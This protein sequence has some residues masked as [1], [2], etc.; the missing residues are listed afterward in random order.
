HKGSN[1]ANDFTRWLARKVI[2]L[3]TLN[4]ETG[5]ELVKANPGLFRDTDLL[6]MANA[7][8]SLAP[9]SPIFPVIAEA[10]YSPDVKYHNIIGVLKNPT[11]FQKKAGRGDG[12]VSYRSASVKD[13]IS[14]L[15][16]DAE[17]TKIHMTGQAIFEVR[18]ILLEH[19]RDVDAGDRLASRTTISANPASYR[20][21]GVL[22]TSPAQEKVGRMR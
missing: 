6:T 4:R 17:H 2:K 18:R 9:E 1:F 15:V 21:E 22:P 8:D 16:I 12:I 19:L 5:E 10:R 11:L 3:P 20:S 13:S 14:E 7:I